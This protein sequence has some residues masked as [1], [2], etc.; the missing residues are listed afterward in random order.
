[1]I[2]IVAAMG[3]SN[4][5]YLTKKR[6]NGGHQAKIIESAGFVHYLLKQN[7]WVQSYA[8]HL[9]PYSFDKLL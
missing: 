2:G 7:E 6:M 1:Q 5:G 3:N 8:V 9:I 4:P